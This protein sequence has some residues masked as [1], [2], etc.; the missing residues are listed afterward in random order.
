MFVGKDAQTKY[1]IEAVERAST[2]NVEA[3]ESV[4][5]ELERIGNTLAHVVAQL[6]QVEAAIVAYAPSDPLT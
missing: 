6:E 3:L 2:A 1:L 4:K 5:H